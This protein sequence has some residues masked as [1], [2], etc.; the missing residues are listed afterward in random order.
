MVYLLKIPRLRSSSSCKAMERAS[1]LICSTLLS[2]SLTSSIRAMY[3]FLSRSVTFA[4]T[5]SA[6]FPTH[7]DEINA[8][9]LALLQSKNQLLCVSRGK[10]GQGAVHSVSHLVILVRLLTRVAFLVLIDV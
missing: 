1:G 6:Q 3:A 9:K 7:I 2:E 4:H 8:V 10:G 5:L